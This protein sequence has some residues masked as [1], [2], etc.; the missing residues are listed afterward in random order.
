M[1]ALADGTADPMAA[2][3]DGATEAANADGAADGLPAGAEG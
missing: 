2:T 1:E 3:D